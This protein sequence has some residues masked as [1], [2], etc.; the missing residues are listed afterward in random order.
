MNM[1][2][3]SYNFIF[4]IYSC[5]KNINKANI[6]Y[7]RFLNNQTVLL[8]LRMKVLIV[9][10]DETIPNN[11]TILDD[12]YLVL[13]VND[14]YESLHIKTLH[15][16][17]TIY[18]LYPQ[19]MGCFKCDDDVIININ[20]LT[21]CISSII[22]HTINYAGHSCIVSAKQNNNHHLM[23]KCINPTSII[24]TPAAIYCGGPLYYLSRYSLQIIN[25]VQLE[26]INHIFYEDLMIG[27]ILNNKSIYPIHLHLYNDNINLFT[28]NPS[29]YHNTHKKNTLFLKIQGGLGNQLFQIA[30]GYGIALKNN[31][32]FFIINNSALKHNFTHINDNN[33]LLN[34]IFK[35]FQNIGIDHINLQNIKYVKEYTNMCFTYNDIIV[36]EDIY[37]DGYLQNEKY[38]ID[39][40]DSILSMFKSNNDF[41]QF[42]NKTHNNKP[43]NKILKISYFIHV[44]RGDYLKLEHIYKIDYDKYYTLAIAHILQKD[45]NAHFFILSDDIA[46]CKTY[47]I[48][49]TI[50]KSFIEL[51]ALESIYFMSSCHKGGICCNSSFSWWGSYL[52]TNPHKIVTFPSKW[53]N[54][55]WNNDIYYK[56]STVI[57]I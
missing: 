15:L 31:M 49:K 18:L 30:S 37:L 5:K 26:Q 19:I 47:N 24:N 43:L 28:S 22:Q 17:K 42:V 57:S 41:D 11:Y 38:F 40:K 13:N 3:D 16:C 9:Y 1:N 6:L 34:T 8:N 56:N 32:N 45:S 46:Y 10:G 14:N 2:M 21:F 53:I 12:K 51:P 36:N 29:S 52:N 7:D 54:N 27:H 25:D 20:S 35:S 23:T 44:R 48:F 55:D 50:Q 39:N 33:Y 4:I